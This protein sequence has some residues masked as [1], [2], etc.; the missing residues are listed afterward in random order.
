MVIERFPWRGVV[1]D[2]PPSPG[3][4]SAADQAETRRE[5]EAELDTQRNARVKAVEHGV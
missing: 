2:M 3:S 5:I 1:Q 4:Q